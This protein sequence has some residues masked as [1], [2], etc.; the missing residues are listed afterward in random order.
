MKTGEL[1]PTQADLKH[2]TT[3]VVVTHGF[4]LIVLLWFVIYLVASLTALRNFGVKP[5]LA[6]MVVYDISVFLR[7]Y[8]IGIIPLVPF[9]FWGDALAYRALRRRSRIGASAWAHGV[10]LILL[11][12]L[13]LS[14]FGATSPLMWNPVRLDSAAR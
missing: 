9:L 10:T 5:P 4:L 12:A 1:P 7:E 11:S 13:V 6:Y 8:F 2:E 3:L 14:I